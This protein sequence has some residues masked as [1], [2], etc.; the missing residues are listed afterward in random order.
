[1]KALGTLVK[2]LVPKASK[3]VCIAYGDW[4]RR[5]DIKGHASGPVKG[6]VEALKRRATMIP[7]DE[8]RTIIACSC[9]HQRLKQTRLFTKMKRKEDE[10]G[11]RQKE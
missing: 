4:S 9:C 6:F 2:R 5:T 1:M 8:Y 10:V 11:I 7:M 3:Q